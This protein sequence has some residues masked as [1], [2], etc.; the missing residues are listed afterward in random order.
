[1]NIRGPMNLA[2]RGKHVRTMTNGFDMTIRDICEECNHGWLHD[3]ERAFRAMMLWAIQGYPLVLTQDSQR[4]VALWATKTALFLNRAISGMTG[5]EPAQPVDGYFPEM[6]S[7][8]S[9]PAGTQ[10]WIGAMDAEGRVISNTSTVPVGTPPEPPVGVVY[11]FTIG[12]VLFHTFL[13]VVPEDVTR[14]VYELGITG[15][16]GRALIPIWPYQVR[17]VRWPPPRVLTVGDYQ[18]LWPTG[19]H[20]EPPAP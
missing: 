10:V 19:G 16:L 6:Y 1:M 12:N 3:L 14:Q 5:G 7:K 11:V 17:D 4:V 20:I 15:D 13:P 18:A 9:P 8:N 2:S